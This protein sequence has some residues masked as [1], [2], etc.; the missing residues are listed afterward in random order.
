MT[1]YKSTSRLEIRKQCID[2]AKEIK[3]L[4][5]ERD[6]LEDGS[7]ME[8]TVQNLSR[9][10]SQDHLSLKSKNPFHLD[11]EQ[12]VD[13]LANTEE[14]AFKRL[15]SQIQSRYASRQSTQNA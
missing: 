13:G 6:G 9:I 7:R 1:E 11:E 14:R 8:K 2:I 10:H 15:P 4:K 12:Q 5:A 3:Q